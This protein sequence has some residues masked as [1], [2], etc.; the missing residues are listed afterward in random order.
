MCIRDS[1]S[2]DPTF[3]QFNPQFEGGMLTAKGQP[4][5]KV[6]AAAAAPI[7]AQAPTPV[8]DSAGL[9]R[10]RL[11]IMTGGVSAAYVREALR[12]VEE[13]AEA[14]GFVVPPYRFMQVG[15]PYPFPE[16]AV[17]RFVEGLDQVFVLEEL[18]HVDV[19]KRQGGRSAGRLQRG[20]F[21]RH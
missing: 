6:P 13:R 21:A 4:A 10:P 20:R 1:F 2:A 3:A 7:P 16:E 15:T 9:P 12:M 14:E 5:D 19:Y 17:E 11:G 8:Q 18:D